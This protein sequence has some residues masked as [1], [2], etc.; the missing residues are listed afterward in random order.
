MI[1]E[2]CIIGDIDTCYP[3]VGFCPSGENEF[4]VDNV[5]RSVFHIFE[6]ELNQAMVLFYQAWF[7]KRFIELSK[8]LLWKATLNGLKDCMTG[9]VFVV[10]L[11]NRNAIRTWR[12]KFIR[13]LQEIENIIN[14]LA[15][16]AI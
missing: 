11:L 9:E 7:K 13:N 16:V 6:L 3:Y 8:P 15:Q 1:R 14:K 5:Y 4:L 10:Q 2:N 12:R